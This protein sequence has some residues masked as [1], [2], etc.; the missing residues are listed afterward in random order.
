[1]KS[2]FLQY[3][4]GY[5]NYYTKWNKPYRERQIPYDFTNM[6]NLKQ[7]KKNKWTKYNNNKDTE[8]RLV[9]TRW[10]GGYGIGEKIKG[11]SC[12]LMDSN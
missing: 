12:M 3:M 11:V 6:W 9:V 1:M 8:T 2:Y 10:E 5:W 7:Q 4:D